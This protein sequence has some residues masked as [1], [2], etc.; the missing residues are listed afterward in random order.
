MGLNFDAE[1]TAVDWHRQYRLFANQV[2]ISLIIR[3]DNDNTTSTDQFRSCCGY[4]KFLAFFRFPTH[5]YKFRH[6]AN[7]FDLRISDGRTFNRV[8]DVRTQVLNDV[9]FLEKFNEN[10]LCNRPIIW[11]ICEV[12]SCKIAG[13]TDASCSFSHR[14]REGFDGFATKVK[15]FL[16]LVRLHLSFRVFLNCEFNVD[17]VSVYSPR[18]VDFFP[19]QSLRTCENIDH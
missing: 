10:G 17:A 1:F 15:K 8:V 16:S 19:E 13:Q 18:K 5:I 12:L 11:G 9:A 2:L 7:S 6:A 3:M 14:L 4:D